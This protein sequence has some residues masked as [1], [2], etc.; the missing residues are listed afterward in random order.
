MPICSSENCQR[1]KIIYLYY[2]K[3]D[4]CESRYQLYSFSWSTGFQWFNKLY[5]CIL[6][7]VSHIIWSFRYPAFLQL[8]GQWAHLRCLL[9][10]LAVS[11]LS[12][13]AF[14]AGCSKL[15]RTFF[16]LTQQGFV[17]EVSVWPL[18]WGDA[19]TAPSLFSL[20]LTSRHNCLCWLMQ[21]RCNELLRPAQILQH[22]ICRICGKVY[23]SFK[24]LLAHSQVHLGVKLFKCPECTGSFT[25]IETLR[26]H[27]R[28]SHDREPT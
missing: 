28:I 12:A 16:S 10:W 4:V 21:W 3:L 11:A 22:H 24:T 13:A 6:C 20:A 9:E 25:Q 5:L 8:L 27:S 15:T 23:A 17:T 26:R 19:A 14:S 1:F 7:G 2:N 18:G